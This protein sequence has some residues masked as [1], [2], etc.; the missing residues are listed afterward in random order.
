MSISDTATSSLSRK[1]CKL[2]QRCTSFQAMKGLDCTT[3]D[4]PS[5]LPY[6]F[7]DTNNG[8]VNA[9]EQNFLLAHHDPR[10]IMMNGKPKVLTVIDNRCGSRNGYYGGCEPTIIEHQAVKVCKCKS[11]VS[12]SSSSLNYDPISET[13]MMQH[14]LNQQSRLQYFDGEMESKTKPKTRRLSLFGSERKSKKESNKQFDLKQFKSVS[15]RC[16]HHH[17]HL[18]YLRE[19][20]MLHEQMAKDTMKSTK[21][22]TVGRKK[23]SI[24]DVFFN[25]TKSQS[26]SSSPTSELGIHHPTFYVPLPQNTDPISSIHRPNVINPIRSIRSRSVCATDSTNNV[27]TL[28]RNV[29]MQTATTTTNNSNSE[30]RKSNSFN[31][32]ES[33]EITQFLMNKLRLNNGSEKKLNTDGQPVNTTSSVTIQVRF[34]L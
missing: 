23:R 5:S 10:F 27:R 18:M 11:R 33:L 21:F 6:Q 31:P 4:G 29:E 9:N 13:Q 25:L 20:Q 2:R 22:N 26:S 28:F 14:V 34:L 16:H 15:M 12:T 3:T 24:Y 17:Q 1:W 30:R 8:I 32:R 19:Q 7:Y